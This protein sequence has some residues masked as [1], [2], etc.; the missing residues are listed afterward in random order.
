M[1]IEGSH[2]E[3]LAV[4]FMVDDIGI[5]H[6]V[7]ANVMGTDVQEIV[8]ILEGKGTQTPAAQKAVRGLVAIQS[9]LLSGYSVH[10]A[11]A[12]FETANPLLSARSPINVLKSGDTAAIALVLRA[13]FERMAT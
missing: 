5:D 12:W 8:A 2:A 6:E 13:A 9:L 1:V 7:M 4:A 11:R 10:G 3:Q